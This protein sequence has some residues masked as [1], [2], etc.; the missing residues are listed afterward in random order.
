MAR[1]S[2]SWPAYCHVQ[3]ENLTGELRMPPTR[4]LPLSI[5]IVALLGA[6]SRGALPGDHAGDETPTAGN[7]ESGTTRQADSAAIQQ[8]EVQAKSI[9]RIDGCT[10]SSDCRAAPVGSR[11]CGGPR[12]YL[13]YC[14]KTTDSAA[15][16][17][18]LDDVA[19]PEQAYT[20][21][22]QIESTCELRLPPLVDASGG[23]SN[24]R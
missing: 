11:G 14:A 20:A 24:A 19:S 8:T 9:A 6:C 18:K 2:L 13:P 1:W 22:N 21:K 16:F 17:G 7:A 15:L 3:L 5:A 10:S 4:A 23:S 12:Y